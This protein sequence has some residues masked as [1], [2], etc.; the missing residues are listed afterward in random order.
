VPA[1][2]QAHDISAPIVNQVEKLALQSMEIFAEARR[3]R[4]NRLALEA[5]DWGYRGAELIAKLTGQLRGVPP[6]KVTV[7][8]IDKRDWKRGDTIEATP[9]KTVEIGAPDEA[10]DP[11]PQ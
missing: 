11:D 7:E 4:D 3:D 8:L 10:G 5:I 1:V 6:E 9:W 2:M